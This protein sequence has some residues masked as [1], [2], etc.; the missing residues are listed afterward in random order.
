MPILPKILCL[1]VDEDTFIS[2]NLNRVKKWFRQIL[3]VIEYLHNSR[4]CHLDIKTDNALLDEEENA[5]LCDFSGLNF[6]D[7]PLDR[8][9]MFWPKKCFPFQDAVKFQDKV[10]I[11][12]ILAF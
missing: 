1:T 5:V 6:T 4:H 8:T 2:N 7:V 3:T 11:S 9:V 10:S 12:G